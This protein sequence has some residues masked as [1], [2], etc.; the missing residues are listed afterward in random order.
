M[1]FK[2]LLL[3][4]CALISVLGVVGANAAL[5]DDAQPVAVV[6]SFTQPGPP[7]DWSVLRWDMTVQRNENEARFYAELDRQAQ[8]AARVAAA[9]LHPRTTTGVVTSAAIVS[10]P[11]G[12]IEQ[13]IYSVFGAN[14]ERA[15]RIAHCESTYNPSA[16]NASGASGLFQIMLPLHNDVF[17]RHGWDPS[18]SWSDPYRNAVVAFDLS[19]GGTDW[20]AWSCR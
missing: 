7:T 15:A 10:A 14:G 18:T 9:R 12:D 17:E 19:A 2:R 13:I 11:S 3:L 6:T 4:C 8:E 20:S 1:R 16:R 5:G